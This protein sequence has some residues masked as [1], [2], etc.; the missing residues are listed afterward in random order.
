[1]RQLITVIDKASSVLLDNPYMFNCV[2]YMLAGKQT[3]MKHFIKSY[4]NK[5]KCKSVL[6]LCSGTGDFAELT[7]PDAYYVGWDLNK[8][9]VNFAR[10]RYYSKENKKFETVDILALNGQCHKTYDAILLISA[11]HH[12]SNEELDIILP[13]VHRMVKKV[14]IIADIIPDPPHVLQRFFAS[15]DR[16]KF[17]RP[18]KEKLRILERYFK[19]INTKAIPTRSAV[20][21]GIICKKK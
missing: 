14:V 15:I 3:R 5:Y 1:M 13:L 21:F 20:Q 2:R 6:D 11:V 18:A 9:F 4:L 12:F 19:I 8:D 16:G 17:I 10:K 7:P